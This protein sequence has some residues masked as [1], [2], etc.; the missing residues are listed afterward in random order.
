[1]TMPYLATTS[2]ADAYRANSVGTAS[3]ARLVGMLYD[4]VLAGLVRAE[5]ALGDQ[6]LNAA[7]DELIR[8]QD[9]VAELAA[10]L[11]VGSGGEVASG[12]AS[13]YEF[14]QRQLVEANLRKDASSLGPV[15]SVFQELREAWLA[16]VEGPAE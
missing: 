2:R 9:I 6:N 16:I 13:L 7:H 1:M 8:C 10:S 11:D 14:C 15:V 3:P 4:G 12:L 5:R